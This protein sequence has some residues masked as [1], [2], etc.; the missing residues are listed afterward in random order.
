ECFNYNYSVDG[1]NFDYIALG[2]LGHLTYAIFNS[3][4]YWIPALQV[5]LK[6]Y[7]SI[8]IICEYIALNPNGV[9]PVQLNDVIFSLHATCAS[10]VW[11]IQ[12]ILFRNE[13][14]LVSLVCIY[15]LLALLSYIW[16]LL[17]ITVLRLIS[18]LPFIYYFS[19][20]KLVTTVTKYT[21]QVLYA[22]TYLL[23]NKNLKFFAQ[24]Q[25]YFHYKRKSTTGFHMG[26][27]ILDLSGGFLSIVQMVL[28][29]WNY[30]DWNSIIGDPT[31]LG[32]GLMSMMFCLVFLIQNYFF[33]K[34]SGY[35][36]IE[37]VKTD[38]ET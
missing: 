26:G 21:P 33:Y 16:V 27:V 32:L 17:S 36:P 20:V 5:N 6:G 30:D 37:E 7:L 29:A 13:D 8:F 12:A 31:K 24:C 10:F 1:I 28:I 2:F 38:I 19:Y 18:W 22:D 25:A 4:L 34:D 35:E 3:G 9:I 11:I 15:L 23:N 14:Q